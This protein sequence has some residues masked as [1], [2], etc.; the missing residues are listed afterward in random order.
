MLELEQAVSQILAVVPP[1]TAEQI[2]VKDAHGRVAAVRLAS[3][4]DLPIFNNSGMDGYAVRAREV[5]A[6]NESSP[7]RL[8]L[9]GKVTAGQAFQGEMPAGSC[10][11][12]FTGSPV[13]EG[14]DAMVMQEDTRVSPQSFDEVLIL[15]AAEVGENVRLRG[16]DVRQQAIL[17]EPGETLTAGRVGLL[18]AVGCQQ[19]M[20]NQAPLVGL[21]ATGSE[22]KEPGEAL[23]P[24]QIYESNRIMLAALA[25]RVGAVPK[26]FPIVADSM[27]ATKLRLR[28]ALEACD[29]VVS[30]GG[31]SVGEMDF[32]KGA[33]GEIGGELE[34][35]KVAIRPGRPFV[36]GR[37]QGKLFFGLPGNPISALVT[38]LLLVRPALLRWQGATDLSLPSQE[39][40]LT[41]SLNNSGERRHFMRVK[42]DGEGRVFSA[43]LQASH[44]LSSAAAAN[45][46]IDVPPRAILQPGAKVRV[47][48][49]E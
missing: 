18:A 42:V 5:A 30:S 15:A 24:G 19:I 17:I 32:I 27:D 49:W 13:P 36:F 20:V 14:A 40:V 25:R 29:L 37:R 45:G 12:L 48:R 31:V 28:E 2:A 1:P 46:L 21:L 10:V 44:A 43:G 41:E 11:R 26:V 34:Y 9:A 38:F 23:L 16:E 39:A 4:I 33:F 22:L 7:V 3:P 35:W 6:A 8:K 47:M